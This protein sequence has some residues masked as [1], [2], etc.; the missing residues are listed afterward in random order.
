M[1]A[2]IASF[3]QIGILLHTLRQWSESLRIPRIPWGAGA[4]FGLL[5]SRSPVVLLFLAS[6]IVTLCQQ[7]FEI[8]LLSVYT[9]S[10][11]WVKYFGRNVADHCYYYFFHFMVFIRPGY[12]SDTLLSVFIQI[13]FGLIKWPEEWF[14]I[15]T[16]YILF[17]L[18][19]VLDIGPLSMFGYRKG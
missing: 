1:N 13:H 2:I 17:F 12:K 8:C 6:S 4:A 3:R 11:G 9:F 18:R 14:Q 7:R 5:Q 10:S 16:H 19:S 15:H